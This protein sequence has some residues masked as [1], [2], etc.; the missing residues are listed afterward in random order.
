MTLLIIAYL[1]TPEVGMIFWPSFTWT[2]TTLRGRI[3]DCPE[4]M[5][6]LAEGLLLSGPT[7][8]SSLELEW[9]KEEIQNPLKNK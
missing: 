3:D 7:M 2:L 4:L 8:P 5:G 6:M 1:Q 9:L